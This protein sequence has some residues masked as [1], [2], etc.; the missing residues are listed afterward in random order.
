MSTGMVSAA[1]KCQELVDGPDGYGICASDSHLTSTRT[2]AGLVRDPRA[3]RRHHRST[4]HDLGVHQERLGEVPG[5]KRRR[6]VPHV[7]SDR[8]NACGV[9]RVVDI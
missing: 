3:A 7:L 9:G 2:I 5:P 6:D 8:R 4:R 1:L